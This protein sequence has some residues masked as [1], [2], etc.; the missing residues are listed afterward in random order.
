MTMTKPASKTVARIRGISLIKPQ[1]VDMG[2][3]QSE[4]VLANR[5]AKAKAK[6]LQMA[7]DADIAAKSRVA[8]ATEAFT[9]ASRA[10]LAG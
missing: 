6:A 5:D 8:S 1:G 7:H 10:V 9:N 2:A 4:I 3:L